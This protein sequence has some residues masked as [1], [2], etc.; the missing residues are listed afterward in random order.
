[1]KLLGLVTLLV[2][3]AAVPSV[4]FYRQY[5]NANRKLANPTEYAQEE[6]RLI[7]EKVGKLIELPPDEQPTIATVTDAARLAEQPFF[8][9][10][11]NGDKVLI[12]TNAKKAILYR[13][14]ANKI[15]EVAPVNIGPNQATPSASSLPS[16]GQAGQAP[17]A[18]REEARLTSS[19]SVTKTPTPTKGIR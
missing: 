6:V 1:M 18:E 11:Q 4:Y 2:I 10:A 5:Q 12:F 13:P 17:S 15:I 3:V 8:A 16:S 7:R 9:N 14:T 19:P